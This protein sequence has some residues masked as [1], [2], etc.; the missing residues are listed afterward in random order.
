MAK[1]T[2]TIVREGRTFEAMAMPDFRGA[3]VN[4]YIDEVVRP[5][6]IIFRTRP[7]KSGSFW[8]SDFDT[9]LEGI[10]NRLEQALAEEKELAENRRKFEEFEKSA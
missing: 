8:T 10:E 1:N 5:N 9:I 3:M 4:Y 6:W 2:V 7:I